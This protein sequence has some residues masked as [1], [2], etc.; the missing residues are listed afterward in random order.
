[1]VYKIMYWVGMLGVIYAVFGRPV[2][3]DMHHYLGSWRGDSAALLI[4]K[5][6]T[7]RYHSRD[8]LESNI[9]RG[10]FNGFEGHDVAVGLGPFGSK[11]KVDRPPYFD[12]KDWKMVIDGREVI[13]LPEHD[14]DMAFGS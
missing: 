1:M 6:G 5:E 10:R 8:G 11:I 7:V 13:K 3:T 2:P 9:M 12:G 14:R 4:S